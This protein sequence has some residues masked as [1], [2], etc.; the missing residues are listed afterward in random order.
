MRKDV[1][2]APGSL[3]DFSRVMGIII[4]STDTNT[5][6]DLGNIVYKQGFGIH[7]KMVNING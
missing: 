7:G 6:L 1:A 2:L 4:N 5:R 3:L